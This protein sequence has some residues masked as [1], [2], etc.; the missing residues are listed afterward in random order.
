[1]DGREVVLCHLKDDWELFKYLKDAGPAEECQ[2]IVSKFIY[3]LALY[4][5]MCNMQYEHLTSE[6]VNAMLS[7]GNERG[8]IDLLTDQYI[9]EGVRGLEPDIDLAVINDYYSPVKGNDVNSILKQAEGNIE[10]NMN[11]PINEQAQRHALMHPTD[12]ATGMHSVTSID[13]D[14]GKDKCMQLFFTIYNK[15][16]YKFANMSFE[17]AIEHARNMIRMCDP[18]LFENAK[19]EPDVVTICEAVLWTAAY[20]TTGLKQDIVLGYALA[21]DDNSELT[22]IELNGPKE[23]N[24]ILIHPFESDKYENYGMINGANRKYIPI[25][26]KSVDTYKVG[27]RSTKEN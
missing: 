27:M 20:T 2:S 21:S 4:C 7:P 9:I 11:A 23:W 26:K 10:R 1:M 19:V 8:V 14:A 18:T 6:T 13:T 3:D 5:K 25:V 15:T 12:I 24:C 16:Y 22:K 17:Q